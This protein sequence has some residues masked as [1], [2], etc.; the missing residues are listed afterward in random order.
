MYPL[1]NIKHEEFCNL[2]VHGE[3][4]GNA[5]ESYA[6]AYG[7]NKGFTTASAANKLMMRDDI[8][9]RIGAIRKQTMDLI[10]PASLAK[11]L[12]AIIDSDI[13]QFLDDSGQIDIDTIKNAPESVRSLINKLKS[14]SIAI[15]G[16]VG[17]KNTIEIELPSK[18]SAIKIASDLYLKVQERE[19]RIEAERKGEES[20]NRLPEGY[21][22]AEPK[23]V[24]YE[25]V[26]RKKKEDVK[27]ED[28][29]TD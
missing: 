2:Y 19:D 25:V 20:E 5:S 1:E 18:I 27:E 4:S 17:E 12:K 14:T 24:T 10:S 22:T 15:M 7:K 23:F 21:E 29:A 11:K 8:R 9:D 3:H 13:V 16:G 26:P 6:I 28:T